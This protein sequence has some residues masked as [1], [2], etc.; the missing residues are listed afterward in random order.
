MMTTYN[1]GEIIL[2]EW[3]ASLKERDKSVESLKNNFEDLFSSWKEAGLSFDD[4]YD[5][6]L[7]KAIKAHLPKP[8]TARYVYKYYKTNIKGFNK[9]EKEFIEEWFSNIE[10]A[11]ISTYHEFYQLP[12]KKTEQV[13]NSNMSNSEY[14]AQRR[15]ASQFPILDT[16]DLEVRWK[17]HQYDLDI[18][19]MMKNVLGDKNEID[20]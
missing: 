14:R 1:I 20:S 12:I 17:E 19:D 3:I 2:K 16:S 6:L 5:K 9:T 4:T 7:D 13:N 10:S 15:Y 11:A 8:A 18:E